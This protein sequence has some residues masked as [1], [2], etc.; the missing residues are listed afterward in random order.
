[1]NPFEE[2]G[3]LARIPLEVEAVL[4]TRSITVGEVLALEPGSLIRMN[5]SAGESVS[6]HVGGVHLADGDIVTMENM[7]CV[8]ITDFREDN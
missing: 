5:R 8:R 6:I 4:D 3:D 2:L 7:I 1:M